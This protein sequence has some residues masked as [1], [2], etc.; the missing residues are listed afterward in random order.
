MIFQCYKSFWVFVLGFMFIIFNLIRGLPAYVFTYWGLL[1]AA[2]WIPS[3]LGTISSVSR[4]G[5][6]MTMVINT[7]TSAVFQFLVGQIVGEKM[8]KHGPPGH[9]YVLAPHFLVLAVL[10]MTGLVLSPTLRCPKRRQLIEASVSLQTLRMAE[11]THQCLEQTQQSVG[12][13]TTRMDLAVG[14]VCAI[15]GGFFSALQY[16]LISIGKKIESA[17]FD[18]TNC[19]EMD[20]FKNEFDSFGSYMISFGVGAGVMTSLYLAVFVSTEKC[21]GREMPHSHFKILRILGSV[22]GWCWV[23]GNV[24]NSAA[25]N[26]GGAS[27]MGPANQAAQL[28][29][30][31]AWGLLYYREVTDPKRILCW[32]LSAAWTVTFVILLGMERQT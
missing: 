2:A 1:G 17:K 13:P 23:G 29:V 8:K 21:Q 14:L 11:G 9:E 32:V 5:V 25:I 22:A 30:S 10:G 27:V 6:G 18:C 28:I 4:I 19:P 3:G 16:G 24:F 7:G 26:R 20:H 12:N 15:G 31:G